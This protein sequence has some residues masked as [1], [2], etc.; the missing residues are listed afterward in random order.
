LV[1]GAFAVTG[2]AGLAST[3]DEVDVLP[4][5]TGFEFGRELDVSSVLIVLDE[6][7]AVLPASVDPIHCRTS[8]SPPPTTRTPTTT[9]GIVRVEPFPPRFTGF[10]YAVPVV[11]GMVSGGPILISL[12]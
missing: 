8:M 12:P 3:S 1:E 2:N 9:M 11:N 10:S 5:V 7:P 6:T 4:A